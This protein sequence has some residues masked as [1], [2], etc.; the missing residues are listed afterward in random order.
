MYVV[1]A[2]FMALHERNLLE[3]VKASERSKTI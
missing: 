2:L 1:E 3:I